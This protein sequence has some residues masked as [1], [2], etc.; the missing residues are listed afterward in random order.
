MI[1]FKAFTPIAVAAVMR[2]CGSRADR[3]ALEILSGML[4]V[5]S[6]VYGPKTMCR[7]AHVVTLNTRPKLD[8][9]RVSRLGRHAIRPDFSSKR[10]QRFARDRNRTRQ[11]HEDW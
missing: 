9:P 1:G 2:L 8:L 11:Y 10:L 7:P 3:F 4:F 5:P 6:L